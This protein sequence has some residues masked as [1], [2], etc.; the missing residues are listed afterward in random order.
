MI[1]SKSSRFSEGV[2]FAAFPHSIL[3]QY[4]SIFRRFFVSLATSHSRVENTYTT[5]NV[6]K[7][8]FC[9]IVRHI[10]TNSLL[11]PPKKSNFFSWIYKNKML[12]T[13]VWE[14]Y[15][16]VLQQKAASQKLDI[17]Q[18]GVWRWKMEGTGGEKSE[19]PKKPIFKEEKSEV[20]QIIQVDRENLTIFINEWQIKLLSMCML[21]VRRRVQQCL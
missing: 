9:C 18:H 1:S 10:V 20:C 13:K 16:V 17:N 2:P 7:Y 15:I 21:V 5:E 6:E 3:V 19:R 12:R 14:A 8:Q 4:L 11:P